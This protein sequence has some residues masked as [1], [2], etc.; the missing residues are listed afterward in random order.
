MD[1]KGSKFIS[2]GTPHGFGA[3]YRVVDEGKVET[4]IAFGDEKEGPP[5]HAHGGAI[6]AMLDETMGMSC[7]AAKRPGLAVNLNVNYKAA[8]PLGQNVR[9]EGHVDTIDG[10]KT[11]TVGRAI[12]P[13]GTIAAESS[14]VFVFSQELFDKLA[15]L[16]QERLERRE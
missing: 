12:L 5:G 9:F 10:R 8:V 1:F 7:F 15:T 14:G 3:K 4:I 2:A 6:A 11:L 13:D 16:Y